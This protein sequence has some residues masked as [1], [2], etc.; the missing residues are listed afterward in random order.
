MKK[1]NFMGADKKLKKIVGNPHK[2]QL[3]NGEIVDVY[4]DKRQLKGHTYW[5]VSDVA[6]GMEIAGHNEYFGYID[7]FGYENTEETLLK[8]AKQKI[9]S[10]TKHQTYAQFVKKRL[11]RIKE[12]L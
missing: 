6:T 4:T 10:V 12:E 2:I 11:A 1:F 7:A 8:I 5:C 3:K 9:D